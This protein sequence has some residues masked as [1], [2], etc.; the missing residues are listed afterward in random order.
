MTQDPPNRGQKSKKSSKKAVDPN[1]P[2]KPCN[3]FILFSNN[4]R[5]KVKQDNPEMTFLNLG[6]ELGKLYK[7]LGPEEK[8]RWEDLAGHNRR[9]YNQ[10]M[11]Q[12]EKQDSEQVKENGENTSPSKEN[13]HLLHLL[14]VWTCGG[15]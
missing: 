7:K 13:L 1:A 6:R 2:K 5:K 11:E 4:I 8:T 9:E 3:A 12:Q 14:Q 15:T 10:A